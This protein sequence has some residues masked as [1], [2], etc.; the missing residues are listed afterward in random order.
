MK[1]AGL[2]CPIFKPVS[3]SSTEGVVY[4]DQQVVLRPITGHAIRYSCLICHQGLRC[5]AVLN[6]VPCE[7]LCQVSHTQTPIPPETYRVQGAANANA[8]SQLFCA[9]PFP[10]PNVCGTAMAVL[11]RHSIM[12]AIIHTTSQRLPANLLQKTAAVNVVNL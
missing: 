12:H 10:L 7:L 5:I 11:H 2:Y 8:S 9:A 1:L 3:L 4:P 6:S